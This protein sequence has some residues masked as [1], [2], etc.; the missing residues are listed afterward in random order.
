MSSYKVLFHVSDNET[1]P[2]ALTNI[3]NFIN[4]VGQNGA[5]IELVANAVAVT[6]YYNQER[7]DLLQ[8][9]VELNGQGVRFTACRNALKGN[10]LDEQALPHFVEV[11]PA[12]IT[13]IVQKQSEGY[14]YIK[15]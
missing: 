15:P 6:M 10:S 1:W 8:K 11:V 14:A 9:M 12:G 5:A 3:Q 13:E 7:A 2:K 4:S